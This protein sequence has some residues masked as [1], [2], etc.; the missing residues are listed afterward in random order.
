MIGWAI[1]LM[2]YESLGLGGWLRSIVLVA[3]AVLT[4]LTLAFVLERGEWLP[5]FADVLSRR[6]GAAIS[7]TEWMAGALTAATT[8]MALQVALGLIFDPRYKDFPFA[9]LTASVV[10]I[11]LVAFTCRGDRRQRLAERLAAA[12]LLLSAVYIVFNES[13]A[14]WQ[15]VWLCVLLLVL[16]LSLVRFRWPRAAQS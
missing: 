11:A 14:N 8:V 16:A 15:S 12:T 3:L 6:G 7:R 5:S 9:P 10:P 4:P 1:E 13:V 2:V